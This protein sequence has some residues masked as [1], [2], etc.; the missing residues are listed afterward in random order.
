MDISLGFVLILTLILFPGLLFR[1][2]YFYEEFSKQFNSGHNL[3]WL[4]A[5]S[6][7]PGI[8]ILLSVYWFYSSYITEI[9]LGEIIDK[10]KDIKNP[11]VR[12]KQTNGTPIHLLLKS[13]VAP[14]VGFLYLL[15]T[16]LGLISGRFIRLSG[17][18]TRFKLLRF[19][20][21]WF[22]LFNGYHT[23]FKKMKHMKEKN[24]KHVFTKAD[25]L[26]DSNSKTHLY[27]GIVVDYEL[28]S[29]DCTALSKVMLQNAERYSLKEGK[30][31]PVGIPGKI[32]V[33]DC[34]NMKN[35]NLTY[36]YE[37]AKDILK[38]KIPNK[39]EVIFGLIIVLL[40]PVFV[41]QAD[42][43]K[44]WAY[45]SYFSLPWYSKVIAYF[46]TIQFI[47]LINPFVKKRG[48]YQYVNWQSIL[49]KI[50]WVGLMI[51]L[52]WILPKTS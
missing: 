19:K 20:N 41:F 28:V 36:I 31:V 13:K 5:V 49:A 40:I 15:S 23:R 12:L 34:S 2:L 48:E 50:F 22:Y 8:L 1:R 35:I 51:L 16:L 26:I 14:F 9:D 10:F 30:R 18:D 7:V 3:V 11:D 52:I 33:V 29:N 39:V 32:L 21:Y 25:I 24:K 47:S 38:S 44:W 45:K 42:A 4:V 43:I 27:S 46:L 37:E 6:T 17:L